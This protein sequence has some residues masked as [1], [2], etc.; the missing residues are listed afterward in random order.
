[1]IERSSSSILLLLQMF[2][3]LCF[4]SSASQR[5]TSPAFISHNIMHSSRFS[6]STTTITTI[7]ST[8]EDV[9]AS[10]SSATPAPLDDSD[11]KED[12]NK[13]IPPWSIPQLKDSTRKDYSRFRQHVNPLSRR[14]KL[15]SYRQIHLCNTVMTFAIDDVSLQYIHLCI[16]FSFNFF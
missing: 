15:Y 4:R 13:Y 16:P 5:V 2:A 10:S 14:C 11:G 9:T 3:T 8:T 12:E 1:M 6:S 7:M